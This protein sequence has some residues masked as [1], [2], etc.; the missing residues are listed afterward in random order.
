MKLSQTARKTARTFS[1]DS[2]GSGLR[3]M[4]EAVIEET[5]NT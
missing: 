1:P 2:L 5:K 4:I 3:A